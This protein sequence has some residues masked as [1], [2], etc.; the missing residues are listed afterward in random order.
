MCYVG[1]GCSGPTQ[2]KRDQR[3]NNQNTNTPSWTKKMRATY[4]RAAHGDE[5]KALKDASHANDPS[6]SDEE[7]DAKDVLHA[8]EVDTGQSTQLGRRF[9]LTWI[10]VGVDRRWSS[11]AV[12]SQWTDERRH[13]RAPF[14]SL[15]LCIATTTNTS[16]SY[17]INMSSAS[18]NPLREET[19]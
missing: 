1:G 17:N 14:L 7:D 11:G 4:A 10:S 15:L 8:R 12:I 5:T 6:Q 2:T 16:V 9:L 19:I 18:I 13:S 3:E